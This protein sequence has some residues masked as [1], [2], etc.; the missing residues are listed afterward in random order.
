MKLKP[1]GD[2]V[3]IK[4]SNADKM[5]TGGILIPEGAKEKPTKGKI[6]AVGPGK[7]DNGKFIEPTVKKGDSVLYEKYAGTEIKI[8]GEERII[9]HESEILAVI[10][11]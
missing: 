6:L 3:V 2:R 5:S 10:D 7:I 11:E 4:Q 1:L 9:V 8:D